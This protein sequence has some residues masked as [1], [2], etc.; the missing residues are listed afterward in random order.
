MGMRSPVFLGIALQAST[1][2]AA[3]EEARRPSGGL[4]LREV[5]GRL[6]SFSP[7]CGVADEEK[8]GGRGETVWR[9]RARPPALTAASLGP[10]GNGV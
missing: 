7:R 5:L 2:H 3:V 4:N 9:A 10:S 6:V 8:G 1:V